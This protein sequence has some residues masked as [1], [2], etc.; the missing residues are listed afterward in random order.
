VTDPSDPHVFRVGDRAVHPIS[1]NAGQVMQVDG[2]DV[3]FLADGAWLS[4]HTHHRF[5]EPEE[6]R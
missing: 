4:F 6:H 5:L 2:D 1:R 3:V